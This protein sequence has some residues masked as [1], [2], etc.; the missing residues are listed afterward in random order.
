VIELATYAH[1][2]GLR[3][4]LS[5]NGNL[6]TKPMARKLKDAGFSYIGVSLDGIGAENDYFRG[7]K[8]AFDAALR[9]IRNCVDIDLKAGLRCTMNAL[10]FHALGPLLDLVESENINRVCFYHLV[11]AGRGNDLRHQALTQE[12]SRAALD[13]IMDRTLD[14]HRRGLE[15]DVLT[16][17]NHCDGVYLY[18]RLLKT[19]PERAAEVLQ[20]LRWNGGNRSGMGIASV[21]PRGNVHPDQ[22]WWHH[23]LG[24]VHE[25]KFGD[26][27]MDTSDP[28]MAGLKDRLP[29]LKGRC[30]LPPVWW[31]QGRDRCSRSNCSG[32]W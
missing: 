3:V 32:L 4:V 7:K 26:I 24:N 12:Q 8:G 21:D 9:G 5:T 20:L 14:F 6:I 13:L 30:G 19:Q 25:R 29:L 27:W 31:S 10:N 17:D 15:K 23:S 22:F 1:G 16:V 2:K 18:L 28:I 11:Y